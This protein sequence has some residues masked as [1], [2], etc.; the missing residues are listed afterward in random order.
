MGWG[1]GAHTQ[2]R[3][4][5]VMEWTRSSRPY[6]RPVTSKGLWLYYTAHILGSPGNL[7]RN[8]RET[9]LLNKL[10]FGSINKTYILYS[11]FLPNIAI[12]PDT[13]HKLVQNAD[14]IITLKTSPVQFALWNL[15]DVSHAASENR[16]PNKER[17]E[18]LAT[19]TSTIENSSMSLNVDPLIQQPSTATAEEPNVEAPTEE[20]KVMH[21]LIHYHVSSSQ[22]K[23][24]SREFDK[25]LSA[26]NWRE[27]TPDTDDGLLHIFAEDWDEDALLILLNVIH[28]RNRKV[29]RS[30]SLE[31]LAKIA[32]L[33]DYYDCLEAVELPAEIWIRGL[34]NSTPIPSKHCRDLMLWMCIAWALKLPEEFA[35][36]TAIAIKQSQQEELSTLGLPI[37]SFVGRWSHL[38]RHLGCVSLTL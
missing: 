22:L 27:G 20:T 7:K 37:I 38:S 32:L 15:P 1:A 30:I 24:S 17:M 8:E 33:V 18:P 10:C 29:P 26:R 13:N 11:F 31:T 21:T 25:M 19:D 4:Q 12:M 2:T 3:T 23:L 36:T 28:L 14:T 16:V 35:Q 9:I 5:R 6:Y 34:K